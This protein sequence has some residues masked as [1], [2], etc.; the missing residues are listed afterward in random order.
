[1]KQFIV[2]NM[3]I[4]KCLLSDV[5]EL[6]QLNKQLIEDEKSDNTM[7]IEELKARM[8]GF[9][10]NDYDAYFFMEENKIIGYAL[11]RH[12]SNPMYLR[13]FYI[14]RN[15]RRQG[16]GRAALKVLLKELKT[17]TIDIEVLS[18]NE[19]AIKFWESCGFVERSRYMRLEKSEKIMVSACLLGQKCKYNGGDNYSEKVID[20]VKGHKVIPVCPELEGGL[21]VPRKPCEIVQ[22]LVMDKDGACKDKQFRCG[23]EICLK[24]ALDEKVSIAILQSRSPSCGVNQIY[25]G[26]FSGK[27]IEGRGIFASLLSDSGIKVLDAEDI[28]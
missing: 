23:A 7:D 20:Y 27:L 10:E 17:D 6:A 14:D 1:M 2:D 15:F 11:V 4:K 26:S 22:G 24:K 19:A 3:L 8:H 25:D 5:E 21:P 13:Q 16:K 9:L 28:E 18:W 12:T